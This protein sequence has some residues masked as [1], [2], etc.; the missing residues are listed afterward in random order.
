V[1]RHPLQ[2]FDARNF[3]A[4]GLGTPGPWSFDPVSLQGARA[5]AGD[6]RP[7]A[8]FLVT[9]LPAPEGDVVALDSLVRF[10][11]NPVRTFLRERLGVYAGDSSDEVR[12]ALPVELEGLDKW[13]VGDRLLE[14]RLGGAEM[15]AAL[16]AERARGM[17]PPGL[18]GEGVLD[19]VSAVVEALVAAVLALPAAAA[20]PESLEV[21]VRLPDGRLLVGT[22]PG[23]RDGTIVRC[24]YSRLGPKHRLAAWVR[25]LAVGAARPDL[26]VSACTVGRGRTTAS[27]ARQLV[28]AAHLEPFPGDGQARQAAALAG[29]SAVVDLYDRGVREPLPLYCATSAAWAQAA[30]SGEDPVAAARG[31]WESGWGFP[32]ED[33][34]PEHTMVLG[35]VVGF[36]ELAAEPPRPD[37]AG[38]GWA[39]EE[40]TRVGRLARRLW[41]GA[42]AHELMEER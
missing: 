35:G 10:V 42:L 5:L 15:P 40:T 30:S 9:R 23:V 39:A 17:L 2:S 21:N 37:E 12:D 36:D 20:E 19:E 31:E 6:R 32:R 3:T 8:P 41:N 16:D 34:A 7:P 26:S 13:A 38:P 1:V 4:G 33:A 18:L 25:F 24:L 28:S 27:G 29:L 11:E 14:A 22:V